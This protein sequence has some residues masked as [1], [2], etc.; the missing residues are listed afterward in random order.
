MICFKKH[1]P[2]G[3]PG[4]PGIIGG[5]IPPIGIMLQKTQSLT[6]SGNCVQDPSI[7]AASRSYPGGIPGGMPCIIGGT[8]GIIGGIPVN[9]KQVYRFPPLI[10]E[11]TF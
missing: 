1:L 2:G 4:I 7:I 3:I 6:S 8:P 10:P 5:I 9:L 11:Q